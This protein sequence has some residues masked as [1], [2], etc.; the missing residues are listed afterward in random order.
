MSNEGF[1]LSE[2]N[3]LTDF[4]SPQVLPQITDEQM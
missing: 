4:S 3:D 2:D 1:E